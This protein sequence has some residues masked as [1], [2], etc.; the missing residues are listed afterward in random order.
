MALSPV[1]LSWWSAVILV[2]SWSPG[3][4]W[5]FWWSRSSW[6]WLVSLVMVVK[7]YTGI[8]ATT[9]CSTLIHKP[10][11]RPWTQWWDAY[12][13][14]PFKQAYKSGPTLTLHPLIVNASLVA[15]YPPQNPVLIL[16]ALT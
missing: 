11:I 5:S 8:L 10:P 16:Q 7:V 12:K 14:P 6:S 13:N 15:V 3:G 2:F 9:L 1:G 4:L